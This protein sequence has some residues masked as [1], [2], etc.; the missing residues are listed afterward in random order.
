LSENS[1]I[2]SSSRNLLWVVKKLAVCQVYVYRL[3]GGPANAEKTTL[4]GTPTM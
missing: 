4:A 2:V 3:I 1:D